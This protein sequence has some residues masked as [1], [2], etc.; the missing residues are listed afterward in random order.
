M[1]GRADSPAV[2]AQIDGAKVL[3]FSIGRVSAA[4]AGEVT[5]SGVR[6]VMKG[7][8][9]QVDITLE[10][11][12]HLF[13]NERSK[14]LCRVLEKFLSVEEVTVRF[15][16][17]RRRMQ[18]I[19]L[20]DE[21]LT[22]A[23]LI[24]KSRGIDG[25]VEVTPEDAQS[26]LVSDDSLEISALEGKVVIATASHPKR[27][28]L[29]QGRLI[30]ANGMLISLLNSGLPAAGNCWLEFV[31]ALAESVR[32]WYMFACATDEY[33]ANN[34]D[35]SYGMRAIGVDYNKGL[36]G[37]Y[38]YN[39]FSSRLAQQ[40]IR[41][42]ALTRLSAFD[43]VRVLEGGV[44]VHVGTWPLDWSTEGY[45]SLRETAFAV[46]DRDLFFERDVS[47]PGRQLCFE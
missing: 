47:K 20:D 3:M 35:L 24:Q 44:A 38:H 6:A 12:E 9:L 10:F 13:A 22:K 28:H 7:R 15:P 2:G 34:M 39:F 32:P 33:D 14:G 36:P 5:P 18:T 30:P 37:F 16:G 8:S 23:F 27:S 42:D 21:L 17:H 11:S 25:Q 26:A 43:C 46:V 31:D 19:P 1:P 4:D 29:I 40:V 41:R 45:R